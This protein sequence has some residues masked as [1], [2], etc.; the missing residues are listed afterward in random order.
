MVVHLRYCG[1]SL[2][3]NRSGRIVLGLGDGQGPARRSQLGRG[4]RS[5]GCVV[6]YCCWDL[7]IE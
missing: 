2:R 7:A 6:R 4:T 3:H 1:G 5:R